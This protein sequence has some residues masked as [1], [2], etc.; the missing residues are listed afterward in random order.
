VPC[1]QCERSIRG[2]D[3]RFIRVD[4]GDGPGCKLPVYRGCDVAT[5]I[6]H[7]FGICS[8]PGWDDIFERG[9]ELIRRDNEGLLQPVA[10]CSVSRSSLSD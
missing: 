10:A 1:Y 6:G 7:L 5:T 8:C 2:G 3:Q 9:Q 4:H